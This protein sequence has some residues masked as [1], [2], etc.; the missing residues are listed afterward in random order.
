LQPSDNIHCHIHVL[1]NEIQIG[2]LVFLAL[3]LNDIM[4]ING[5]GSP[6]QADGRLV[7]PF[8]LGNI[9]KKWDLVLDHKVID[10]LC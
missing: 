3:C 5:E 1:L 10:R 2:M 9:F 8:G 7:F 6:I 4:D